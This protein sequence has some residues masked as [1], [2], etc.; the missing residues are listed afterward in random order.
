M[1]GGGAA[2]GAPAHAASSS[3]FDSSGE[4]DDAG[5]SLRQEWRVLRFNG[6][7]RQSVSRVSV[8]DDAD[9]RA[10]G[11]AQQQQRWWLEAGQRAVAVP[12]C[13]AQEYLKSQV[14]LIAALLGLHG[15][16]SLGSG[17]SSDPPPPAAATVRVLCIGLGGGSLPLFLADRF[18]SLD[19]DA[20]E[21]DAAVVRAATQAM[22]LPVSLPNLRL[23]TAD[24]LHFVA[25]AAAAAAAAPGAAPYDMVC[26]DAFDGSDAVPVALYGAE[27]ARMVAGVLH[28]RHGTF[29]A[30]FHSTDI[31]GIATTFQNA[32]EEADGAPVNC[33][34]I[35]T[36]K[37]MNVTL[38]CCRGLELPGGVAGGKDRLRLA[39]ACVADAAGFPFAAGTRASRNYS[40]L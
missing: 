32:M 25:A 9:V 23:H 31:R 15:L 33:F 20:V 28:P 38:A 12:E 6:T 18:P 24:A 1:C 16:I 39:A 13:L 2:R 19:I 35:S 36:Q 30:N 40:L 34:S 17:G 21:I 10:G 5:A 37:Q 27:F 8:T 22:G 11:P 14:S 26:L 29:V 4:E 3:G 7:T